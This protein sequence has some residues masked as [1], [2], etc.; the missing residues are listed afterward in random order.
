MIRSICPR[1]LPL[2]FSAS[3]IAAPGD[4]DA[5]FDPGTRLDAG[6]S[7]AVPDAN[8]QLMAGGIFASISGSGRYLARF[9]NDGSVDTGFQQSL[10]LS[11]DV[12]A[13]ATLPDGDVLVGG[14]F[15]NSG[16]NNHLCRFNPDGTVDGGFNPGSLL[17][18]RVEAISVQPDGKILVGGPFT[19]ANGNNRLCRLEVDGSIDTGFNPGTALNATV[20]S[21]ALQ[22]DGAVVVSGQFINANGAGH[23]R[24]CR[25]L[26]NGDFDTSFS[27]GSLLVGVAQVVVVQPD[28][29]ILVGGNFSDVGSGNPD[30]YVCRLNDD[31][32]QDTSFDPGSLLAGTQASVFGMALQADG[33]ILVS[34]GFDNAGGDDD[35]I[36]RLLSDGSHDA[37]FNPA[38]TLSAFC[39]GVALLPSGKVVCLGTFFS[40]PFGTGDDNF[41]CRLD[42]DAAT[43]ALSAT[44]GSRVQWL[45]GGSAPETEWVE[46]ELSTDGGTSFTSLGA[47]N[48]IAG[49]WELTGLTLPQEGKL[50]ARARTRG[51][52]YAGSSGLAVETADYARTNPPVVTISGAKK[53]TTRAA[54]LVIRGTATDPDGDLRSVQFIDS[55]TKG[56]RFRP[57]QGLGSWGANLVL[58]KGRN[59]VQVKATDARG[60]S[61]AVQKVTVNRK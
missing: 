22:A 30:D 55:R 16:G 53:I 12:L 4:H 38:N 49:G 10:Q 17:N 28:G 9:N 25:F 56:K 46:F 27:P 8:G 52:I 3:L 34:G 6:A 1:L 2:F 33:K 58:K 31:G 50:R 35:F 15:T 41:L 36:C 43:T 40:V 20:R 57:T 11:G 5:V 13:L 29:K 19:N 44:S 32:T 54:K 60:V 26:P 39:D 18:D 47:G 59:L 23:D 51:G 48:R 42:N 14:R 37:T 45:R 61:S 24:V 21:I 7:A